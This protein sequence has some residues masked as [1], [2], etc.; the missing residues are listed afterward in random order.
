VAIDGSAGIGLVI[1]V[2]LATTISAS[3]WAGRRLVQ[4]QE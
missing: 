1:I 3:V 2:F 4:K